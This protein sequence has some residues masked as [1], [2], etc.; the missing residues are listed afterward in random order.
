[1]VI[2][3]KGYRITQEKAYEHVFGYTILNDVSARDLQFR[4]GQWFLGKSCDTFAPM[5][6]WIVHK[7]A[8]LDPQALEIECRI[9]GQLRQKNNTKNMIFDIP[10]I[11]GRSLQCHLEPGDIIGD[12]YSA[13]V[14]NGF[15]SPNTEVG[16]IMNWIERSILTNT[17]E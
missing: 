7:S 4:H 16:A 17:I 3:K 6:P 11:I 13:G 14:G 15:D 10:T 5:G 1:M 9:N 2:G 12:G 8:L